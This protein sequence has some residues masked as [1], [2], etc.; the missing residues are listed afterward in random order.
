LTEQADALRAGLAGLSEDDRALLDR[1][2][3]YDAANQVVDGWKDGIRSV[4]Q[5][6]STLQRSV[7]VALTQS[8]PVPVD[9]PSSALVEAHAEYR[10][11][12]DDRNWLKI[13]G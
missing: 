3:V 9:P 5:G 6:A 11:L 8:P 2:K 7:G 4:G 13:G 12:L 1:G 10:S